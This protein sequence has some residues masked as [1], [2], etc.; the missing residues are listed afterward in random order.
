MINKTNKSKKFDICHCWC[1]LDKGFKFQ[2]DVCNGCYDLLMMSVNLSD[3]AILNIHGV[4]YYFICR[5]G[6][7]EVA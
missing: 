5:I 6:K 7:I 2:P 1:F 4:D 3:V